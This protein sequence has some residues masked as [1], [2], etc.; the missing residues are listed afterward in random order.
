MLR[1]CEVNNKVVSRLITA[2]GQWLSF[3][4]RTPLVPRD[5]RGRCSIGCLL[6][7]DLGT[8]AEFDLE[9]LRYD[10]QDGDD[11]LCKGRATNQRMQQWV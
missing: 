4:V 11:L 10:F 7:N 3:A 2:V 5:L 6:N 9:F 8:A 1:S